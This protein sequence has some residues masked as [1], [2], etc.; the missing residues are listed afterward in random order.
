MRPLVPGF[1]RFSAFTLVECSLALG[2]MSF[3]LL[4]VVSLLPLGLQSFRKSIDISA[5]SLIAQRV[6]SD[7]Q[8]A[9]FSSIV[10]PTGL[11]EYP[12]R[13]FDEQG[14]E[15][16]PDDP[17]KVYDVKVAIRSSD[18]LP[19]A[20]SINLAALLIDSRVSDCR[21]C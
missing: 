6:V 19:G 5:T 21:V 18:V 10:D 11:A 8:Q 9:D 12:L 14:N 13:F 2:I 7:A 3:S 17:A 15:V 16:N 4:S 20:G 1:F